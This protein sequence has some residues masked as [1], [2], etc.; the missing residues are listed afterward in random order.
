M[1]N[2]AKLFDEAFI[3][4][5]LLSE[6]VCARFFSFSAT[7]FSLSLSFLVVRVHNSVFFL[8]AIHHFRADV[9]CVSVYLPFL[10]LFFSHLY[11]LLMLNGFVLNQ[12][13]KTRDENVANEQ[14]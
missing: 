10:L 4:S 9:M 6:P 3:L 12:G 1:S 14:Y 7:F 13:R 11:A 8:C 5:S 2:Q